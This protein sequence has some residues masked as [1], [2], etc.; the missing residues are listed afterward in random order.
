MNESVYFIISFCLHL[1]QNADFSLV[2]MKNTRTNTIS[3]AVVATA[4]PYT[5]N[6]SLAPASPAT[7]AFISL[8]FLF[9]PAAAFAARAKVYAVIFTIPSVLFVSVTC[10]GVALQFGRRRQ[11]ESK[12]KTEKYL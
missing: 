5:P 8:S 11:K 9:Y 10:S 4:T 3:T 7:N 12:E 1:I 6:A 2:A